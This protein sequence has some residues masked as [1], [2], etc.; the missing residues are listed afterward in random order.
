[1]HIFSIY[2]QT[3]T[4]T[5]VWKYTENYEYQNKLYFMFS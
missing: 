2:F 5:Y 4:Y 3:Y 1:M